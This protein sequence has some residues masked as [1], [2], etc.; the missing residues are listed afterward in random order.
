MLDTDTRCAVLRLRREGHGVRTIARALGISRNAA[1]QIAASGLG[2][3]PR[4]HRTLK[5]EPHLERIR[6]LYA[7]CRGNLARVLEELEAEGVSLPYSTLTRFCRRHGIGGQEK[8]PAGQYT[9]GPGE[10]MQHDT[11]PH[12]AILG[13]RERKVQTASLVMCF[14]RGIFAQG[15]PTF[16]RFYCRIFFTDALRYFGGAA[17]RAMI[18]NSS[19]I[20]AAGTGANAV[21][22]PE[23]AA[24]ARHF[25]F[26]FVA[27]EVGDANRSARVERQFHF[28][29]HN[30]YAGRTFEN[31]ADLNRQF[32][33]WCDRVSA[34]Y[35]RHLRA[36]PVEL[37][38][39][40]RP[41]LRA[42]PLH[43]PEVYRL[44]ERGVDLEGYVTV[45]TNRYS[46]PSRLIG[47]NVEVRETKDRV[48]IFA[49]HDL[50]AE[51]ERE[52]E[53]AGARRTLPEHEREN[54]RRTKDRELPP[55][56]Q[57]GVLRSVGPELAAL[58]DAIRKT[59]GGRAGHHLRSL[60]RLYVDY[61]TA[62]LQRAVATALEHGLTDPK[63]IEKILLR[64]LAGEFFRLPVQDDPEE[65][66]RDG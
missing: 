8:E 52:E 13:G 11:S 20:I 49:G 43:I 31:W 61:P 3:V 37:F 60:H 65:P 40:E 28:I 17:H 22:A 46:A 59:H 25:G 21:P 38:Q 7:R 64:T 23:M 41:H 62:A 14:S 10:E 36:R 15:Y 5:A 42:L 45:K 32:I 66:L 53:G 44:H 55:L 34:L 63:R 48:R 30:F 29:E 54:R 1:R 19:V 51:H 9:F 12:R 35:R 33:A 57:E 47:H 58:I 18:D 4:Q 39:T 50:V 27:H 24:L 16:D 26:E 56:P 2:E 6:D